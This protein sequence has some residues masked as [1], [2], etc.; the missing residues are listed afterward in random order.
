M[1][2]LLAP[3]TRGEILM[4]LTCFTVELFLVIYGIQYGFEHGFGSGIFKIGLIFALTF[5]SVI[6]FHRILNDPVDTRTGLYFFIIFFAILASM[7]AFWA[8]DNIYLIPLFGY[9]WAFLLAYFF[10]LLPITN[11]NMQPVKFFYSIH[12]KIPHTIPPPLPPD[13]ESPQVKFNKLIHK[14]FPS[15]N[16]ANPSIQKPESASIKKEQPEIPRT[17][18]TIDDI[19]K[20]EGT[21]FER[22]LKKLFENMGYSAELTNHTDMGADLIISKSGE[23]I[24]VQAK[25]WSA[26]VGNDAI[27]AVVG[28]LKVYKTQR[29]LVVTSSDFTNPAI[30]Q[31]HHN[32]VELWNRD[33]LIEMITKYPVIKSKF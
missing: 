16:T 18:I 6:L 8:W 12:N 19:D 20:M 25:R 4:V 10:S 28:S 14:I 26:N 1:S 17:I 13:Y 2:K 31:A 7:Y 32:H 3:I 23:R 33:K 27:Q 29:G 21:E 30:Y 11:K 22:F 24:S 15:R 5:F 9:I